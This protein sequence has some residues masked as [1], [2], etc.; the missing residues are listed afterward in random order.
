MCQ[1]LF[2][3]F[4][5]INGKK[6]V[7]YQQDDVSVVVSAHRFTYNHVN[8]IIA[9]NDSLLSERNLTMYD[10]LVSLNDSANTLIRPDSIRYRLSVR[11][12]DDTCF[13]SKVSHL[14]LCTLLPKAG[15]SFT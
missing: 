2:L 3:P 9:S 13:E 7:G 10:D 1:V 12:A 11:R 4:V 6:S 14:S 15:K 8:F 5:D